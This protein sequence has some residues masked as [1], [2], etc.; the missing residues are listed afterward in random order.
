MTHAGLA[1]LIRDAR[2]ATAVEFAIIAPAFLTVLLG[3]MD[4]G[5]NLYAASLLEGA[6]H[7]AGR[8]STI[9]GAEG[10]GLAEFLVRAGLLPRLKL[11][12]ATI[13]AARDAGIAVTVPFTARKE[14]AARL[15]R[16][17]CREF[18]GP[19]LANPMPLAA[20]TALILAPARPKAG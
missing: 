9:E 1:N 10:R 18:R 3:L 7:K 5:Y 16:L 20:L 8:D 14:E 6:V 17:G 2:G 11:V 4:Q 13:E 19:L 15:L 12:E